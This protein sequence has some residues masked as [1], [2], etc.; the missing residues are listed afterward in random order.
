MMVGCD[1]VVGLNDEG[2]KDS[3]G[4][5][6]LIGFGLLH[7]DVEPVGHDVLRDLF[8]SGAVQLDDQVDQVALPVID[9]IAEGIA[10]MV[11]GQYRRGI[12]TEGRVKVGGFWAAGGRGRSEDLQV[13]DQVEIVEVFDPLGG[14]LF[15][16]CVLMVKN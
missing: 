10:V 8:W 16:G 12:S 5:S 1:I 14:C 9:G 6:C 4:A 13:L 2:N 11:D 15:H 7:E 3:S